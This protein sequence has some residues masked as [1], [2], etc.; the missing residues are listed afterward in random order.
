MNKQTKVMIVEDDQIVKSSI[1]RLLGDLD[2]EII[3]A[4]TGEEGLRKF[5]TNPAD[6]VFTDLKLPGIDGL[7][8]IGKMRQISNDLPFVV[9]SAYGDNDEALQAI[10]LG[11]IDYF[12]KPFDAQ[13]IQNLT[14]KVIETRRIKDNT[15]NPD[16]SPNSAEVTMDRKKA[17]TPSEHDS[18]FESKFKRS[19][20][21]LAPYISLGRQGTG[22]T[23]NLNGPLTGMMG[24]LELLKIKNPMLGNDLNI[25]M[26][27]AKKLRD[28]IAALQTKIENEMVRDSTPMNIN[29]MLRFELTFLQSDLFFKHY[30]ESETNFQD[31]LPLIKG[32]YADFALAFEEILINAIDCQRE[33]K[34]GWI[35]ITTT[36]DEQAIK[37]EIEDDG[38]GFSEEA[39]SKGFE[40]FWPE[41]KFVEDGVSHFGMGL[42][43]S[44][45]WLEPY[46]GRIELE[47]RQ[48]NGARVRV[49]LPRVV[50]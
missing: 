49:I 46:G 44:R 43:L 7:E 4:S 45:L 35:R 11:V 6:L 18:A 20:Q 9:L 28:N 26:E 17:Q 1:E 2:C 31:Q 36:F 37:V 34:Q 21:L 27:L 13:K 47:N 8:M 25:V 3:T 33:K 29:Q 15:D 42:Y 5:S 39:L 16:L 50:R 14:R 38:P 24:N 12:Q 10:K 41:V 30:I 22:I 23:H 40:P 48:P 32:C 19:Y